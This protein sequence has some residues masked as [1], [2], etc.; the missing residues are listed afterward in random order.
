LE[1][2]LII[3]MCLFMAAALSL[4]VSSLLL[5]KGGRKSAFHAVTLLL[6]AGFSMALYFSATKDPF[7]LALNFTLIGLFLFLPLLLVLLAQR[8]ARAG[9]YA[10]ARI[11][12]RARYILTLSPMAW[13]QGQVLAGLAL[14]AEEGLA[15]SASFFRELRAHPRTRGLEDGVDRSFLPLALGRGGWEHA[16]PYLKDMGPPKD[17]APRVPETAIWVLALLCEGGRWSEGAS[18]LTLLAEEHPRR[19]TREQLLGAYAVFLRATG[20]MDRLA[21][22]WSM[23]GPDGPRCIPFLE[24]PTTPAGDD[25]PGI[26]WPPTLVE[27]STKRRWTVTPRPLRRAPVTSALIALNLLVMVGL[28][29]TGG[30]KDVMNLT[31]WGANVSFLIHQGEFWRMGS[32]VFLHFGQLHIAMN[33]LALYVMGRLCEDMYGSAKVLWVY[34]VAGFAGSLASL[35]ITAPGISAGAS[36]AISGLLGMGLAF[37]ILHGA[38]VSRSFRNRY[39]MV[40]GFI[41][42]AEMAF[43][44]SEDIVGHK[45]IDS[46]AHLG[47]MLAGV[48]TA[49]PLRPRMAEEASRKNPVATLATIC[50]AGVMGACFFFAGRNLIE[51]P[52]L[53]ADIAYERQAFRNGPTLL[54]PAHWRRP[55]GQDAPFMGFLGI[56]FFG[57]VRYTTS[58]SSRSKE[59]LAYFIKDGLLAEF[60][61]FEV[62]RITPPLQNRE[63]DLVRFLLLHRDGDVTGDARQVIVARAGWIIYRMDFITMR[64]DIEKFENIIRKMMS[65]LCISGNDR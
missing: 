20:D 40:F 26:P 14:E 15:A 16:M 12:A 53:P 64:R 62:I 24:I 65:S 21:S 13:V 25:I 19:V 56:H 8:S 9:S 4:F 35:F 7:W 36:G 34:L 5:V 1:R 47:G 38:K 51:N 48:L 42:L 61:D 46:A 22:L 60:P 17:W 52:P 45:M 49:L 32:S 11:F 58:D 28:S 54:V 39:L 37:T 50:A 10:A 3:R 59:E 23:A 2:E 6:C 29:L 30:S 43:G 63:L 57:Q 44:I 55:S 18:L 41:I 33:L 27:I 31:D